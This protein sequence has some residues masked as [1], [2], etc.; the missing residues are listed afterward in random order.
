[1][2]KN[3]AAYGVPIFSDFLWTANSLN[4]STLLC[5][6]IF[7]CVW[8]M[9]PSGFA[10]WLWHHQ[11]SLYLCGPSLR[12]SYSGT[13]LDYPLTVFCSFL[14]FFFFSFLENPNTWKVQK[15]SY[16]HLPTWHVCKYKVHKLR[17]RYIL[18]WWSL[19]T[20]YLHTCQVR[21]TEGHSGLCCACV[22]SFKR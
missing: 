9:F 14:F 1:M 5:Y 12:A 18:I 3:D 10:H 19:C 13:Q 4:V 16:K 7:L 21:V 2:S 22:T 15:M 11:C 6:G 20:L 17:Q 8:Q